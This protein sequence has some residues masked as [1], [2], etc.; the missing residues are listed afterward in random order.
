MCTIQSQAVQLFRSHAHRF[1]GKSKAVDFP[2]FTKG[3]W[4]N[5]P[6]IMPLV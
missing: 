4:K 5:N 3:K 2:D 1:A 6:V